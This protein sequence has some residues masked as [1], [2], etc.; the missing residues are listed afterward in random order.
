MVYVK[1]VLNLQQWINL[2]DIVLHQH[3]EATNRLQ[4]M[5][6]VK[7]VQEIHQFHPIEEN[8]Y[9]IHANKIKFWQEIGN[10]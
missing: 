4:E 7:R 5:V 6:N 10:A 9:Q 2:V 3:A 8:V 1:I